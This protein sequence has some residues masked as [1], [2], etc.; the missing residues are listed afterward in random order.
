L[1]EIASDAAGPRASWGEIMHKLLAAALLAAAFATPAQAGQQDF[2][3][4][5]KTGYPIEEVYVSASSKD[6]WEEDVLGR[7]ILPAGERTKISFSSDENACLW[8][9][10]VVYEDGEAAEWQGVNLCEISVV[11][12]S[13]NRKTGETWA[14]AE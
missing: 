10:K 11:A 13:Y 5:N 4:L 9:L 8:D 6:E 7:D 3:I 14:E 1:A 2:V 12:L